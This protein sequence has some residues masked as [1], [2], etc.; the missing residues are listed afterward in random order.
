MLRHVE[1]AEGIQQ[2]GFAAWQRSQQL[3]IV[4]LPSSVLSLEDGAFQG[5]FALRDGPRL[6]PVQSKSV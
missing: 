4:K 2:V 6:C 5:Y 3:Q 1:I